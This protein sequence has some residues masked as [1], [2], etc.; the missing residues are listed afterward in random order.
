MKQATGYNCQFTQYIFVNWFFVL[1]SLILLYLISFRLK[2]I[3]CSYQ[4]HI[5][6]GKGRA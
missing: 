2:S 1:I 3:V 5:D 4:K 6:W